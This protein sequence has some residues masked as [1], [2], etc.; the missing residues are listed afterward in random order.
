[1]FKVSQWNVR[2]IILILLNLFIRLVKFFVTIEI[3][4]TWKFTGLFLYVLSLKLQ[5]MG[6][7]IHKNNSTYAFLRHS[8]Y[9]SKEE[10]RFFQW[11][12]R[13]PLLVDETADCIVLGV[14]PFL[15]DYWGFTIQKEIL[16]D[17]YFLVLVYTQIL[18]IMHLRLEQLSDTLHIFILLL[19]IKLNEIDL[20]IMK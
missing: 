3:V 6:R 12:N 4:V 16:I 20:Y 9:L 2:T 10:K 5:L 18:Q 13:I 19:Q 1:M 8:C 17:Y 15:P 7:H 14:K 11:R